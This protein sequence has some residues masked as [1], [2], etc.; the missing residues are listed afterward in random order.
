MYVCNYEHDWV[1]SSDCGLSQCCHLSGNTFVDNDGTTEAAT[2][3][4]RCPSKLILGM[5]QTMHLVILLP[6]SRS[7]KWSWVSA[8]LG[9]THAPTTVSYT[10]AT[11]KT[12]G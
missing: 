1:R 5:L 12:N 3:F 10:C 6:T 2:T 11:P 4:C 7:T 8:F 9:N